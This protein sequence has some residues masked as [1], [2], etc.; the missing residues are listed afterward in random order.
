MEEEN[1]QA[2]MTNKCPRTNDQGAEAMRQRAD[3][4]PLVL[5]HWFFVGHWGLVITLG[6]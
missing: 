4:F 3:V 1:D 2:S 5:G 6:D